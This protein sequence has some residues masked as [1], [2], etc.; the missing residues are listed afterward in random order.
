MSVTRAY[1]YSR[2][3]DHPK[4]KSRSCMSQ[5][6]KLREYAIQAGYTVVGVAE[7]VGSGKSMDR[8]GLQKVMAAASAGEMDVLL[9]HS[10]TRLGRKVGEVRKYLDELGRFGVVVEGAK[11]GRHSVRLGQSNPDSGTLPL[12]PQCRSRI[13][14]CSFVWGVCSACGERILCSNTP[15]DA[16]CPDCAKK[17]QRCVHCGQPMPK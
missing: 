7:D 15:A 2:G 12:C 13:A 3:P 17:H 5:S 4:Y 9:V 16:L 1:L 8:P 6:D 14:L 10:I 11:D